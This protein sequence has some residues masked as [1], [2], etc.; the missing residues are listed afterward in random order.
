MREVRL[1]MQSKES[2]AGW[3]FCRLVGEFE[4][5]T[6]LGRAWAVGLVVVGLGRAKLPISYWSNWL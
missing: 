1:A 6:A 5:A 4:N 2:S 3:Y